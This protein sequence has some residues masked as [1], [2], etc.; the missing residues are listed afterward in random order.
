MMPAN[1]Y[2]S[3]NVD[4]FELRS[5]SGFALDGE[6]FPLASNERVVVRVTEPVS[7]L[8]LDSR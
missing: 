3:E 2:R 5:N 6:I 1:G 8:R 7:F 4:G